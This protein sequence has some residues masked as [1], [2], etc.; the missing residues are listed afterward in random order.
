[1]YKRIRLGLMVAVP[2][3]CLLLAAI[4]FTDGDHGVY[5]EQEILY[6]RV[7]AV[8]EGVIDD[9]YY[10]TE[11]ALRTSAS[12]FIGKPVLLG[13][14]WIN[15]QVCIGTTIAS[16]IRYDADH[17][18]HYIEMILAINDEDAIMRIKKGLYSRLSIGFV[19]NTIKCSIDGK[20]MK[21]CPHIV[22]KLYQIDD[23]VLLARGIV[24]NFDGVELSF[25][26][27]PASPMARVLDWSYSHLELSE[28][29]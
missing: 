4:I 8:Y 10:M 3:V 12:S 9:R 13:H 22:G 19:V 24:Y 5:H 25:V 28:R 27:V 17:N 29:N 18:A 20:D 1:M 26:N 7:A 2:I 23:K 11:E 6:V 21:L 15:P 14:N 16:D